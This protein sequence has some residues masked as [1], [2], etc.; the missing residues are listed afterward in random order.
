LRSFF[1]AQ[2]T[3]FTRELREPFEAYWSAFAQ[4]IRTTRNE[5]GHPISVDPVTPDTVHASLLIFPELARL[6]NNLS[7]WVAADLK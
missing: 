2:M 3:Q 6:A 5:A 7:R 4:Q 1:E